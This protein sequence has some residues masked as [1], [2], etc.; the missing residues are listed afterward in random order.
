[1]D[2]I[3]GTW[4]SATENRP[5][6]RMATND[7]YDLFLFANSVDNFLHDKI[8][9]ENVFFDILFHIFNRRPIGTIFTY[10]PNVKN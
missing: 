9:I 2:I 10:Q 6:F 1:M 8:I 3:C 4:C 7:E 5:E